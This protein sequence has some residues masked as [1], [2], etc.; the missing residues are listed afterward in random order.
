MVELHGLRL[1]LRP[2]LTD[3]GQNG[4]SVPVLHGYSAVSYPWSGTQV[5]RAS[6]SGGQAEVGESG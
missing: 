1:A 4:Y 6:R 2:A 3:D 5:Q